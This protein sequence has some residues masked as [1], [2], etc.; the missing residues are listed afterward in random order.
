MLFFLNK[1]THLLEFYETDRSDD[2]D[3]SLVDPS[4]RCYVLG[5]KD[6]I[7]DTISAQDYES[8]SGYRITTETEYSYFTKT[9]DKKNEENNAGYD[10]STTPHRLA[11]PKL[12]RSSEAP[13]YKFKSPNQL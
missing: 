4:C 8:W 10:A 1:T 5:A 6:N 11:D 3:L 13:T 7:L 9:E 12:L 2:S